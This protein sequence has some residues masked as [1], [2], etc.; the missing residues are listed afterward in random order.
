MPR[1][2][3]LGSE[4]GHAKKLF[5]EAGVLHL[6]TASISHLDDKVPVS[7]MKQCSSSSTTNLAQSLTT[8]EQKKIEEV[9]NDVTPDEIFAMG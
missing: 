4:V 5:G 6:R 2:E 3:D 9:T 1:R 8:G 7:M